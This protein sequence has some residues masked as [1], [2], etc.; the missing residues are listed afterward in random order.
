MVRAKS[1]KGE[2]TTFTLAKKQYLDAR[3]L[4]AAG[5]A[6]L[7]KLLV[8][9]VADTSCLCFCA[10]AGCPCIWCF[11]W[12]RSDSGS[13]WIVVET[14]HERSRGGVEGREE[15]EERREGREEGEG[16]GELQGGD[17]EEREMGRIEVTSRLCALGSKAGVVGS[18]LTLSDLDAKKRSFLANNIKD[19]LRS[20]FEGRLGYS[21]VQLTSSSL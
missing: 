9:L 7:L 6:L 3:P 21:T 15:R 4:P 18:F 11:V 16:G 2:H 20:G 1:G 13:E 12:G 5:S 8:N 17:E 10:Q 19:T 14:N